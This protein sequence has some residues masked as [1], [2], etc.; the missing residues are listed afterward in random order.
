MNLTRLVVLGL[1]AERGA[2]HGHQLRHDIRLTKADEWAGVGAGSLHRELRKL[3]DEELIAAVRVER[4]QR[5]P[6]RTIYQITEAGRA[7]LDLLREQAFT[8]L[9]AATDP[10]AAALVFTG[11]TAAASLGDLLA[12]HRAAVEAELA[13]LAAERARGEAEGFLR[14]E[15]SAL[16]AAAFRRSELR[17]QAE[18]AWHD[19]WDRAFGPAAGAPR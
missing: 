11:T 1:L 17:A 14:P 7:E 9:Q 19:E 15:V 5:R 12:R 10:V 16:Q 18:L 6:E 4:V 2:Q 3:A 8:S 13:R